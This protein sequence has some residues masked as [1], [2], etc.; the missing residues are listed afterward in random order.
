MNDQINN[1][2]RKIDAYDYLKIFKDKYFINPIEKECKRKR[3]EFYS[4][5]ISSGNLCFDIGT[6]YGN[7]SEVFLELGAEVIALEP[8][9]KQANYLKRK[10]KNSIILEKKAAGPQIGKKI[11]FISPNSALSSLSEEWINIVKNGRFRKIRWNKKIEIDVIT[12]DEL[13]SL[14]GKPDYCKIDVEGYELD[15]LHGLTH[16]VKLLSFEFTIPEFVDKAIECIN[17]LDQIGEIRCNY[18]AG[19]TMKFGMNKWI[20]SHEFIQKFSNLTAEDVFDGD[21]YIKFI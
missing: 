2:L 8:Q 10:F 5:F 1:F 15:V 7:R 4:S 14:Y 18:S 20:N 6:S 16:P 11:M 9:P 13:I 12:I 19:E 17:Y 21:I 3:L